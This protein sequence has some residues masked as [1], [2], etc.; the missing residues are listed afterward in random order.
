L[1]APFRRRV[2]R[3][4]FDIRAARPFVSR[5]IGRR[6]PMPRWWHSSV[7]ALSIGGFGATNHSD[8]VVGPLF[9]NFR[10]GSGVPLRRLSDKQ[11]TTI[12]FHFRRVRS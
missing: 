10:L 3:P 12:V 11:L 7:K 9:A 5:E 1:A 6:E 4:A 8:R 2:D